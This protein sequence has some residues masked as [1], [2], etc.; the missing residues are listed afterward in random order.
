MSDETDLRDDER[1]ALFWEAAG[2]AF[3]PYAG[4]CF[5]GFGALLVVL[6]YFGVSGESIVAKQLP[7]LVSGGLGGV[8][9]AVLGAYVLG[10]DALRR[11]SG[12]LDR[13]ERQIEELHRA[14]LERID[15]PAVTDGGSAPDA[16]TGSNGRPAGATVVLVEAGESFHRPSCALV[17]GKPGT[18]LPAVDAAGRGLRPCPVCEPAVP[19][20]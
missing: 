18:S 11:D 20:P 2:N 15:A 13:M 16:A 14:L 10:I 8:L 12:R 19:V 1:R 5:Y 6:G 17:D 9:L 4:W 7:Y 3:R